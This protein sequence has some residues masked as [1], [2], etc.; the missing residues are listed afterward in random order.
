MD[1]SQRQY[2]DSPGPRNKLGWLSLPESPGAAMVP[3]M[4]KTGP[5][6]AFLALSLALCG[7]S[8]DVR[9]D[10]SRGVAR[11]FE[12]VHSGD[13]KAF[14][15]AIDRP[16]LRADIRDQLAQLGKAKGLDV[17]EGASE[18]ALD[19]MITPGAFQPVEARTG[20]LLPVAP[21][22]AQIALAMKVRDK[23]HVCITDLGK[24]RCVLVF[25]K[26]RGDWRLVAMQATDLKIEVPA[27]PAKAK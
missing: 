21:T 19:R 27:A 12:A 13:R 11:F 8:L 5:A 1:R 9:A 22:A 10:A 25:A 15:A 14:E 18:F 7:C 20:R 23:T 26:R 16:A 6:A 3:P 4:F 2:A 24:D 17:G